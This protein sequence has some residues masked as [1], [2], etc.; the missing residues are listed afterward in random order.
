MSANRATNA[1]LTGR[2]SGDRLIVWEKPHSSGECDLPS[3]FLAVLV[4]SLS[5]AAANAEWALVQFS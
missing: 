2:Q 3:P 1:M 5:C 4:C